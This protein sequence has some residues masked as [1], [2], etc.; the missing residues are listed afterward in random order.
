M[1]LYSDYKENKTTDVLVE[2]V[3]HSM[4]PILWDWVWSISK[5]FNDPYKLAAR[6]KN[7]F[8]IEDSIPLRRPDSSAPA[9]NE[10]KLTKF[11]MNVTDDDSRLFFTIVDYLFV[12][13]GKSIDLYP[14]VLEAILVDG[15]HKFTVQTVE[16][17]PTIVER[18]PTEQKQL[19]DH[20][21]EGSNVYSSE[22]RDAFIKLYGTNSNPSEATGEAFQALESALKFH[23]G[24]DKG[25]NLGALLAWLINNK[26]SWS[27]KF[28]S[29][30]QD[31][32]EE[33]FIANVNFVNKSYRKVKHGQAQEK[34]TVERAHAEVNIR[35][36]GL[37]IFELENTIELA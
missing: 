3:N 35:V 26:H 17:V 16:S 28:S 2:E 7:M 32:A 33:Q 1:S 37:L 12:T 18:L 4:Y 34:L 23:I 13:Y 20:A 6:I 36:V 25:Q 10:Y 19:M 22:F 21:L 31:D 30:S 5:K 9:P 29:S 24:D 27:Y 8:K 11:L 14:G 15:G